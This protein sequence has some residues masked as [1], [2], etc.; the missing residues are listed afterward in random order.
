MTATEP[1]PAERPTPVLLFNDECGVCRRIA[2]WVAKSARSKSGEVSIIERPIGDD[3]EA[4]RLLNPELDIWEAYATIHLLMPDGSMKRGGEAVA[5]VLRRLSNTRWLARSFSVS[6]LGF[7]PFQSVLNLAYT[8]LAD[9]R[10]LFGCES[11]GSP[12]PWMKPIRWIV[13]SV[14]A[15]VGKGGPHNPRPHFTSRSTVKARPPRAAA[16]TPG[17]SHA[18]GPDHN[19]RNSEEDRKLT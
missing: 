4:L 14:K 7:R 18:I 10:P 6:V 11:C 5:E 19:H 12:S 15:L 2:R 9:T 8:V 3:P 16:A 1:E 17:M 13:R